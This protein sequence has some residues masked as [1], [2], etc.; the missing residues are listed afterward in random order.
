MQARGHGPS[1]GTGRLA[2][3]VAAAEPLADVLTGP[4]RPARV[5]LVG[6]TAAYLLLETDAVDAAGPRRVVVLATPGA[7]VP[8]CSVVLPPAVDPR[9]LARADETVTVGAGAVLTPGARLAV[10]RWWAPV[11]LPSGPPDAASVL[12]FRT[13]VAGSG[14]TRRPPVPGRT[15]ALAAA[16]PAARALAAGNAHGAALQL[17]PVLGLGP[18][19]TPSGDDVT[20]GVL[21]AARAT[22]LSPAA[23]SAVSMQVLAAAPERTT[24]VSAALLAEAAAGRAAGPVVAALRALLGFGD[25]DAAARRLLH[26]GHTSGADVATGLLAV[27][28]AAVCLTDLEPAVRPSRRSA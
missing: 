27:A 25:V 23:T 2:L 11:V 20:A 21:L 3:P 8:P 10:R 19:T 15:R 16:R 24:A 17:L 5:A 26:L 28:E 12:R 22:G 6:S 4:P 9:D 14:D 7:V 18:G 1:P 13:L